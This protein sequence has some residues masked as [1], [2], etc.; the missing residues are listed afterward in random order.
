[1]VSLWPSAKHQLR[2]CLPY[3]L[4]EHIFLIYC[5]DGG[6]GIAGFNSGR[7]ELCDK[8]GWWSTF[9][10][11][12]SIFW[13]QIYIDFTTSPGSVARH[14]AN[15]G[16]RMLSVEIDLD[17]VFA[18]VPGQQFHFPFSRSFLCC[19]GC[20]LYHFNGGPSLSILTAAISWLPSCSF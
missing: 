12:N 15:V 11:N 17:L 18:A 3:E 4:W 6:V 9:I 16:P 14:V 20:P 1:M 19:P 2:A 8:F 5:H 7:Y 13:T 10:R